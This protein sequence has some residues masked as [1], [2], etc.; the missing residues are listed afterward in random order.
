MNL[1]KEITILE[2]DKDLFEIKLKKLNALKVGDFFQK[3]L[4]YDFNPKIP[5]K[6]I[7]LRTNGEKTTLAIKEVIDTNAIDGT[8]ELEIE[9][10]DFEKTKMILEE[11]G[12]Y[13][14]NYQENLRTIYLLDNVEIS[15]DTWPLIPTY[16]EIEGQSIED[17]M[18]VVKKLNIKNKE[19]TTL[20]VES[21]YKEKKGIDV[22]KI[23]ELKL[24]KK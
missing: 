13:P 16:V 6:W 18:A 5:N 14:K 9:V 1:E 20:D 23:R 22:L 19:I 3:R 12:Y 24:N 2:V 21:I 11:L 4:V 17:V 15:I 8:K 10:S 7:R